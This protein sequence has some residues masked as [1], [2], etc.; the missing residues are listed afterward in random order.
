MLMDYDQGS[1]LAA[2]L[3]NTGNYVR[4]VDVVGHSSFSTRI[5]HEQIIGNLCDFAIC[6]RAVRGAHTVFHLAA[7]MGGMGTIHA[8]ND[9]VIYEA[10]HL[11][12]QN[13]LSASVAAGVRRLFYASSACVYPEQ[14]QNDRSQDVSLSEDDVWKYTPPSSQGLY[15]LEKLHSENLL[16]Q[17]KSA[18][19]IRVARFHN[20]YG[21][22]G[23]WTGGREKAPA[24]L[25]RKALVGKLLGV[26]PVII[27]IWGDGI[28]RRSFLFIDDAIDAILLLLTSDHRNPVNIGSDQPITIL[29]LAR[30]AVDAVGLPASAVKFRFDASKPTGV[31]SRNS[32]NT[33]VKSVLGWSPRV[34]LEQ[35]FVLTTKW[36]REELERESEQIVDASAYKAFLDGLQRSRLVEFRKESIV[37]A[38]LLP[39]T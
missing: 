18:I 16:H 25:I 23:A 5:C 14:L 7:A 21:P 22:R 26:S 29:E 15:G 34:T 37:F 38:I 11:M 12:T 17:Y 4:I 31:G 36:I 9:F 35:G 30:L 2:H 3:Y 13:I 6:E 24:A 28:Q 33:L 8:A 39:I 27:E 32:D 20:V 19:D 10:N 1:H